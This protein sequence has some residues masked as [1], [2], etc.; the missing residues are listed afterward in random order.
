MSFSI[1]LSISDGTLLLSL[2]TLFQCTT[3]YCRI[4]G[5]SALS[6]SFYFV[7]GF[8]TLFVTSPLILFFSFTF[9]FLGLFYAVFCCLSIL[10]PL[11]CVCL[12]LRQTLI[13]PLYF[14]LSLYHCSSVFLSLHIFTVCQSTPT[15]FLY[16]FLNLQS[17]RKYTKSQELQLTQAGFYCTYTIHMY[18]YIRA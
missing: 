10:T 9:T 4:N 6:Y 14:S 3:S 13:I 5:S 12:F 7:L 11:F 17:K 16:F 15:I 8:T 2:V 18:L 1:L